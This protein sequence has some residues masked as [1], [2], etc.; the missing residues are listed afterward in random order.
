MSI[1]D[2]FIKVYTILLILYKIDVKLTWSVLF[3]QIP[4]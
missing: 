1:I 4:V 2:L 3:M